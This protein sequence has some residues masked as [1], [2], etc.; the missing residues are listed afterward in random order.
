MAGQDRTGQGSGFDG[1][2][3]GVPGQV[4][5]WVGSG[6]IVYSRRLEG[7]TVSRHGAEPAVRW[8]SVRLI[9]GSLYAWRPPVLRFQ[10]LVRSN[11]YQ[12]CGGSAI[13]Q[14]KSVDIIKLPRKSVI[15]V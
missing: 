10:R 1:S 11:S 7:D 14:P 3:V 6:H 12:S 8:T 5:V 2:A 15:N 13:V 4:R 9:E